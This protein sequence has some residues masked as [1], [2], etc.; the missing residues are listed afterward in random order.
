[1]SKALFPLPRGTATLSISV[2]GKH[3]AYVGPTEFV[4]TVV[5]TNSLNQTLRIDISSCALISNDR[6]TTSSSEAALFVR[7]APSRQLLVATTNF[8]LLKFDSHSGKLLNIVG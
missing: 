3:T 8:K 4:V 2:D 7:F 6:R 5:E 1:M